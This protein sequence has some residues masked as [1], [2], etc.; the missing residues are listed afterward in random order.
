MIRLSEFLSSRHEPLWEIVKQCGVDNVVGLLRGAEQEQ[1]MFASVGKGKVKGFDDGDFT[2][3]SEESIRRD[4]EEFARHGLKLIGIEDTA[5]MDRVRLGL[6]GRDEEI[7]NIIE[8]VKVMG[9]LGIP[10]LCYNWMALSSWAR[11]KVDITSRGGS[12]V[13]G[14]DIDDTK[15]MSPLVSPGEVTSE[16]LWS[17]LEYFLKA[18]IPVA[19]E[20]GVSLGMH[21]DD[22]PLSEI[23]GLPRIMSSLEAYRKLLD[24]YPSPSNGITFCQGNFSLM[25]DDLPSAIREFGGR[26]AIKFVHFRDIKGTVNKFEETFQDNGQTDM[27]ECMRAYKEIDFDG[28]IRPDH[29]PTMYGETN[30]RPAYETL[31]RIFALGYIRG[32]EQTIYG[33]K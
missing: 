24:L 31:G 16:Q 1:R 25:T 28:P 9:R 7:D 15:M 33:K 14:F 13:T 10:V 32:L 17:S 21:P 29:V 5:P 4:Q 3:W 22:P 30:D 20:A 2:P 18:V 6:K 23:R 26:K 8:Q 12:L 19:E 11:T 27:P